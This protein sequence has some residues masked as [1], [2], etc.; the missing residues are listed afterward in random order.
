MRQLGAAFTEPDRL[1]APEYPFLTGVQSTFNTWSHV[2]VLNPL[3]VLKGINDKTPVYFANDE[4]LNSVGQDTIAEFLRE[5]LD[6]RRSI[7]GR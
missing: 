2:H 5:K 7:L 3:P 6:L 4:H 1:R